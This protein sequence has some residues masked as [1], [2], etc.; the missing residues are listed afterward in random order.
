[1]T[2]TDASADLTPAQAEARERIYAAP[3]ESLN[4]ADPAHYPTGDIHWIFERLRHEDPV[5]F[6]ARENTEHGH[7]WSLTKWEDIQAADTNH[8][9][10]SADGII[11]LAKPLPPEE[12]LP[13]LDQDP[14]SR[15][16]DPGEYGGPN[17]GI[18]SLLSMDP[19][20]HEI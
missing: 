16:E 19:P 11:T 8:E 5:H 7:Y 3:L 10:F 17:K 15:D 9:A 14:A 4:P 6:T 2:I 13:V 20:D 12:R 18:R 1:M